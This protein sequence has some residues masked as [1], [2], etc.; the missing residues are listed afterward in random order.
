MK[1]YLLSLIMILL[2]GASWAVEPPT[3]QC[4]NM[5]HNAT[6]CQVYWNHPNLY[7]GISTIQ[8]LVS[9]SAAGPYIL[10]QT[11]NAND[12]VCSTQFNFNDVFGSTVGPNVDNMYCYLIVTPD[13]AHATEGNAY[14]DTMRCMVLHLTPTGSNPTQ[15]SRALLQWE[16]P[17][18]FPATCANQSFSIWR[19]GTRDLEP[20]RIAQVPQTTNTYC[21]TI[22][23]CQ[24]DY[25][26]FVS[27][28]NYAQ[29]INPACQFKTRI[30]RDRFSDGTEPATPTLDSVSVN[31]ASQRIEL[32]WHQNSSDAIGCIIYHATSSGGPWPA[33]DT[34]LGNHWVSTTHDATSSHYY[35][36]AAIDSCFNSGLTIAGTMTQYPQNNMILNCSSVDVCRK[37]IHLQWLPYQHLTGE[38]GQY[39][40]FYAQDNGNLQFLDQ[41]A[42]NVAQYTCTGLA[43]NHQYTF[44]VK[45]INQNGNISATSSKFTVTNY[46]EEASDDLCYIRHASVIDNQFV[47]I[48]ILTNGDNIPFTELY[49]YRSQND[50]NHFENIATLS[51]QAGQANY[52]YEDYSA[53]FNN[54]IYYY[55]ASLLNEC[56]V[57]SLASNTAK[58]ILLRGEG[59]AAQDNTLE[60]NNYTGFNGGTDNYSIYRKVE[61]NDFFVDIKDGVSANEYNHYED[62]VESLFEMGSHFQYYVVAHEGVNEYGFSEES[63]SNIIEAEQSPNTYLPNAFCPNS[64]IVANRVFKPNNSFMST[65]NYLFTIYSRYGD[66]VFQTT[67]ITLG[68]DG[69]EQKSGKAVPR[70][71]YIY[72]LQFVQPDGKKVVKNGTVTLIY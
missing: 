24:E 14:S 53:D 49:I 57:E 51:Y 55:K 19:Q 4:I 37:L 12:T 31:Y 65:E 28:F 72:R 52:L 18:P 69:T 61:I 1:R 63:R 5:N 17:V 13:A 27:I 59:N 6:D 30:K 2:T 15:N 62:N 56:D 48:K 10:A 26:Y 66:I 20:I 46:N 23:V 44:I 36:I 70:G 16:T 40:I 9:T 41:V 34:V 39:Q 11:V 47:E 38:V 64:L 32:G 50:S 8:V 21:D 29:D 45:A 3:L 25:S 58:T 71:I 54:N 67:D 42:A 68:W 22:Q 7:A 33:V 60:W 35:R 43:T